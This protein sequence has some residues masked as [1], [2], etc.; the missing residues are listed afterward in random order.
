MET[1]PLIP[2]SFP[3][4]PSPATTILPSLCR[5]TLEA[6][7]AQLTLPPAPET[8][9]PITPEPPPEVYTGGLE[10]SVLWLDP[11][12]LVV[13]PAPKAEGWEW[14]RPMPLAVELS[15]VMPVELPVIAVERAAVPQPAGF[16]PAEVVDLSGF[17]LDV[18]RHD[19]AG[20]GAVF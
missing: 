15:R 1:L 2:L 17:W 12:I 8:I 7:T 10:P 19:G 18:G 6:T 16:A 3:L 14:S 9:I 11:P 20:E 13:D 4:I 5:A